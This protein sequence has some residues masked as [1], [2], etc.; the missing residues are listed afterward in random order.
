MRKI[1]QYILMAVAVLVTASCSNELDEALQPAGNGNLQFVVGDFP[2]FGEGVATRAIGLEDAGKS[3]W[4]END[5]IFV[6]LYSEEY[7]LQTVQINYQSGVWTPD[8]EVKLSYLKDETP[9]ITALYAPS[10]SLDGTV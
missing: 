10:F 7:G 8:S 5:A 4:A 6:S 2:A 1:Y 9:I 3:A